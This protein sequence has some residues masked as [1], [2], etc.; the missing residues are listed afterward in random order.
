MFLSESNFDYFVQQMVQLR[1]SPLVFNSLNLLK[2]IISVDS[3][4]QINLES[5]SY[6]DRPIFDFKSDLSTKPSGEITLSLP[7]TSFQSSE[8]Q[9]QS[10]SE[11][12]LNNSSYFTAVNISE[13]LD[14][15]ILDSIVNP[16]RTQTRNTL[17]KHNLDLSFELPGLEDDVKIVREPSGTIHIEASND[18]ELFLALGLVHAHDRLWQMDFQRRTAGGRLSEIL[19]ET[20]LN[21]DIFQR[22]LGLYEAAESAY[23]NLEPE[24]QEILASYTQGIN[25]YLN[26]DLPLPLEFQLLDYEPE[27][28]QPTDI[29]ALVKLQSLGVSTNLQSELFRSQLLAQGISFERIQTLFPPYEGDVTILNAQEIAQIPGLPQSNIPTLPLADNPTLATQI[30]IGQESVESILELSRSLF[31][32]PDASNNWVVS[33]AHTTTGKPFLANDPHLGLGIPSLWHTVHLESPNLEAIGASLPGIPAIVIGHNNQITWGL[34][35]AQVDVQDVYALVEAIPGEAYFYQGQILPYEFRDETIKVR[36]GQDIV[37]SVR[38]SVYGPVISDALGIE[39]PLAL[40]WVSLDEEDDTLEAFLGINRAQNWKEFTTALQ[41]LVAPSEN[42]VYADV[43][44]NIGYIAPGKIPIR[45]REAGHTGLLPVPGTGE[46]DWQGFIPFEELPQ[47]FNPDKGYIVTANNRI[48]PDEYPYQLSFEWAEPYRAERIEELLLSK[49]K[50]SLEDMQAIQLDQVSLLFRD[51]KPIL[52]NMKPILEGLN[53]R[54][55]RDALRWLNRLLRWDG[56]LTTKSREGTVFETWYNE[57]TKL[58]AAEIGEEFLEGFFAQSVP[59]FLIQAFTEGDS[60]CGDSAL[61]CLTSAAEIFVDVIDSFDKKIP[62]WGKIHQ[63]VFEHPV[64]DLSR[65]VPFGGD[66]YTVNVGRYNPETF[67]MDFGPS[68]RQIID[69]DNREDS[70]FIHPIGQSGNLFSPFFDNLLDFWQQGE[71]IP[72]QTEDFPI[73]VELSLEPNATNSLSLGEDPFANL[74]SEQLT[75]IPQQP[76]IL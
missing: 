10:S 33:G 42:F 2:N 26:L 24:T 30:E 62:R 71:Y 69:L 41:S 7:T 9:E 21:E 27:P 66:R 25:T 14:L 47:V 34:S 53:P 17:T 37:I 55:S 58:V 74:I 60:A 23:I 59:R 43:E 19:G 70:L 49:D 75:I 67:L 16:I 11:V 18:Q 13:S 32:S 36:G 1:Y 54:P 29:L 73:A 6:L 61:D 76:L 45:N 39:Q 64:L 8:I 38:E 72:M 40:R 35:N 5:F 20:T 63:T 65:Q 4:N 57:L 31:P 50:L 52:A 48:A 28:W 46:F 44:G 22:S 68:Y 51:F 3:L 56:N 15:D 12:L